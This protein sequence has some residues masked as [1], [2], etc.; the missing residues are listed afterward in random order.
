MLV[1]LSGLS[2]CYMPRGPSLDVDPENDQSTAA[3]RWFASNAVPLRTVSAGTPLSDLRPLKPMIRDARVVLLGQAAFGASELQRFQHRMLDFLVSELDFTAIAVDAPMI[4]SMAVDRFVQTGE[5]DPEELL[6]DLKSWPFATEEY[7]GM[8][9]WLRHY[10]ENPAHR[11]KLHFY[12]VNMY[13]PLRPARIARAYLT[14]VEPGA[15]TEVLARLTDPYYVEN[16]PRKDRRQM[17]EFHQDAMGLLHLADRKKDEFVRRSSPQ[18]WVVARQSLQLVI[19]TLDPDFE[20]KLQE[21]KAD[22][23]LWVLAQE[24]PQGKLLYGDDDPSMT[25]QTQFQ[26]KSTGYYLKKSLGPQMVSLGVYFQQGKFTATGEDGLREFEARP[27]EGMSLEGTLAGA[28]LQLA[29]VDLRSVPKAGPVGQ[30]FTE[31]RPR[32]NIGRYYPGEGYRAADQLPVDQVHEGIIFIQKTSAS[33][34]LR[35]VPGDEARQERA[36]N[37]SFEEGTAGHRPPG[38]YVPRRS[39]PYL[40]YTTGEEPQDG[41]KCVMIRRLPRAT[42][43]DRYGFAMQDIGGVNYRGRALRFRFRARV[44]QRG[45]GGQAHGWIKILGARDLPL[46]SDAMVERPILSGAWHEYEI[47]TVVPQDAVRL[48]FGVAF[49]GQGKALFDSVRL[50]AAPGEVKAIVSNA[51]ERLRMLRAPN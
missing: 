27:M 49:A 19:Q 29:A 36:L 10:N 22:N 3:R 6:E 51:A 24:G 21:A 48:Q 32:R 40:V 28:G 35:K 25:L 1:S 33:K 42:G 46:F 30:W 50:E 43:H 23:L 38:W 4:E 14:S 16:L 2:A 34:P 20:K 39:D 47:S 26:E 41:G 5:G 12:G 45:G 8:I 15:R 18:E 44:E 11:R 37:L 9:H 31:A 7:L 13:H 17:Q